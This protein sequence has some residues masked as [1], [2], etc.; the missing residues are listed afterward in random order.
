MTR[1]FRFALALLGASAALTAC[2]YNWSPG[3]NPQQQAGFTKAPPYQSRD[4]NQDSVS[5][6]QQTFTPI[7][8]GSAVAIR[9]GSVQDQLESAPAGNSASPQTASGQ[10]GS[11]DDAKP[12]NANQKE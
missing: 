2:D 9:N 7:G 10:T 3:Q 5:A 11:V 12:S 4:L 8:K 6:H 1:S